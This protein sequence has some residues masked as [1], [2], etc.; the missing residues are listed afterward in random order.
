MKRKILVIAVLIVIFIGVCN[1]ENSYETKV[2]K[3]Y[4]EVLEDFSELRGY[5]LDENNVSLKVVTKNGFL[6]DG[7]QERLK[8]QIQAILRMKSFS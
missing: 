2:N 5:Y 6:T 4:R 8:P 3:L 1:F 7:G